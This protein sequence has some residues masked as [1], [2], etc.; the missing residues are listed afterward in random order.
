MIYL[1]QLII[2]K[3]RIERRHTMKKFLAV[4]IALAMIFVLASCG[5]GKEET[6]TVSFDTDGGSEIEAQVITKGGAVVKPETPKK[7][8]YIFDKW[9]LNGSEYDFGSA[10]NEDITL[11]AVWAD[12]NSGQGESG[13]NSN[14]SG[15]GGESGGSSSSN[16]IYFTVE[17]VYL[18]YNAG[19]SFNAAKELHFKNEAAADKTIDWIS[20]DK[21]VISVDSNG[22]V[23]PYRVGFAMVA[24]NDAY[25]YQAH[26]FVHAYGKSV[27]VYCAGR[28]VR[29]E[30]ITLKAGN[31]EELSVVEHTYTKEGL[32]KSVYITDKC[33]FIGDSHFTWAPVTEYYAKL[34]VAADTPAGDY[35]IHFRNAD[36]SVS[37]WAIKVT[38]K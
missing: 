33:S 38:V 22:I 31:Q 7:E 8:G 21:A 24:A 2:S 4:S 36:G 27:N 11:K 12:P 3:H 19:E 23:T 17:D 26:F 9:T 25:D 37:S 13:G 18:D 14:G 6:V 20:S 16:G 32:S 30:G 15:G 28:D 35:M 10:V 29:E 1:Y 34:K 5:G